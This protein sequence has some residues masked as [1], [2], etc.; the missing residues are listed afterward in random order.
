MLI[1][2]CVCLGVL[3]L[4]EFMEGIQADEE[5]LKMLTQTLDLSHIV[6]KIYSEINSEQKVTW[7]RPARDHDE[8]DDDDG[9]V[10]TRLLSEEV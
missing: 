5:L 10:W 3:S 7:P 6:N 4:D 8:D 9:T 1:C 2:N